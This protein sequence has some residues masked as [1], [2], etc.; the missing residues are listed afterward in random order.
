MAYEAS[1]IMTAVALQY[2]SSTLKKIKTVPQLQSL[3]KAGIKKKTL[4]Q[5][6][7]SK[8]EDGFK[9]LLDPNSSKMIEDMAVGVSAAIATRQY[10]NS[11]GGNITTYMTGNVWP[12]D[13]KD[14]QV[15]AYGFED[16]NSSDIVT[17][18]DKKTFYGISLKKKKTVKAADPT[19]INKAFSSAFEGKEFEPLKKKLIKTRIDYFA[20]IVKEA[21]NKK[22]I[23]KK[24]IKNFDRL[25]NKE[26]FEAKERNKEQFGNKAYIDTK[27]Y[28]TSDKGYLDENTKDSKSMRF[29]VN[30]RLSEKKNNKLWKTFAKLIDEGSEK[31]ADN[32]I[33]IILKTNLN[34][35]I[36][37]K[38]LTGKNFSFA[39][40]TGIAEV[41]KDGTVNIT[42][43]KI[44]TLK[45]TLCGLKRIEA[46]NKSKPYE[47]VQD[48]QATLKSNAAKIFFIL[49]KG[50]LDLM[51]L[52]VRYKG[53]FTP[54]PQF[55]GNMTESFK[56][57]IEK[58]CSG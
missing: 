7:N 1:E 42:T 36:E 8:I 32:L 49:K 56:K 21:I 40:M 20:D 33:N 41:K 25:S 39:L 14:F 48:Q 15:S 43:G 45:T 54:Q 13:V 11:P 52:E 2:P 5:F 18:K 44:Y 9:K 12:K 38:N 58:E 22:I 27:G 4:V 28:A 47:I 17:S 51:N 26:L 24:D 34:A 31:L 55:Q 57:E 30:E 6:G 3:I 23:L 19:L 16:Y 35:E 50:N 46:K 37:A 53:S 29:F 10:M